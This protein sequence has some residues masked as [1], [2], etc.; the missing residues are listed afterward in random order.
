VFSSSA[1]DRSKF[2]KRLP[3][4]NFDELAEFQIRAGFAVED[5]LNGYVFAAFDP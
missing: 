2:V 3:L 4:I 5:A 1:N